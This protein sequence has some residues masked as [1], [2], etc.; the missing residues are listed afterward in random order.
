MYIHTIK[1]TYTLKILD[2][3]GFKLIYITNLHKFFLTIISV[4]LQ[5]TKKLNNHN[6]YFIYA[7]NILIE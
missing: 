4:D 1:Q 5:K 6:V 2:C 7:M 3:L